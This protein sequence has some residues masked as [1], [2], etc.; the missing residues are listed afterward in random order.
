MEK[1]QCFNWRTHEKRF[2][3]K[4]LLIMRLTIFLILTTLGPLLA[5]RS[6]SQTTRLNLNLKNTTVEGVLSKIETMTDFYFLYNKKIIDVER[7][8]SINVENK[9]ITDV[10]DR[11]FADS[12][13]SYTIVG[14]QIVLSGAN[15]VVQQPRSVSGKVT[16]SSGVPVPGVSVVIKGTTAGIVTDMRGNYTLPKVPGDATLV[17]SFVGMKKQEIPVGNNATINVILEEETIGIEEVV[18]IGYGDVPRSALGG[19]SLS[20]V[21]VTDMKKAT[22][23]SF[24]ESLAGRVAGV[25]IT[26]SE[27]G[28]LASNDIVIRGASSITQDNSPLWVVDGFPLE[29][30]AANTIDPATIKSIFMWTERK[31]GVPLREFPNRG[32]T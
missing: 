31:P 8:V 27:G 11:L 13:V 21:N 3:R 6:Y 32:N 1:N 16:D 23:K 2:L 29:S 17:F 7:K 9:E 18:A 15:H 4:I 12:D 30:S 19:T 28:P 5:V 20:T 10:L 22:V 25:Q 24:E 14:R 26:S